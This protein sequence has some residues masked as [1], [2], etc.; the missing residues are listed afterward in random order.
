MSKVTLFL[1]T[2]AARL[3]FCGL[4]TFLMVSVMLPGPAVA[5]EWPSV[6]DP[7]Q[8]LTVNLE[9]DSLDWV[10]IQ[11]DD[12]F[13]IEVPAMFW[14]N[15]ETPIEVSVRRKSCDA[16]YQSPD[17]L[18]VSLKI[19]INEFVPGQLWHG[20]A[21]LRLEN[22]DDV[23]VIAEGFAWYLHHLASGDEGY[24]YPAGYSAWV[25]LY[26]NGYYTGVYVNCE[27]RDKQFLKNHGLYVSGETWLY[28]HDTRDIVE[29]KVGD[30]DSPT[31]EALC[32]APFCRDTTA[33]PTPDSDEI[34][35]EL[36]S[37]I[38]MKSMF[39]MGAVNTFLQNGDGLLNHDQNAYFVDFLEGSRRKYYPHD[40]DSPLRKTL[41]EIYPTGGG[42]SDTIL[43]VPQFRDQYTRIMYDL[44]DGPLAEANLIAFLDASEALLTDALEADPNNQVPPNETVED[45]FDALRSWVPARRASA[46]AQLDDVPAGIQSPAAPA[47]SPAISVS[48][49]PFN[50]VTTITYT[51][52]DAGPVSLSV[53]DVSGRLVEKILDNEYREPNRYRVR[54]VASSASGV[55]FVKL[56]SRYQSQI[57]KIVLLK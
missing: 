45:Q 46:Y 21:K 50:P 4:F 36:P 43:A 7:L 49:N 48:P 57:K 8:L 44:L 16:L 34:A 2:T 9:L 18:K 55:Y 41:T 47:S 25:K 29:Q 10:T 1:C 31:F 19:D 38:D 5:E 22:G 40:L 51:V 30:G 3:I 12:T 13:D 33:C 17:F 39:T 54:Y 28:K 42:H 27:N 23:N 35:T 6:F 53:Y 15:G 26:I 32:Y 37:L 11:N 20:L 52:R 14:A 24:G 56:D